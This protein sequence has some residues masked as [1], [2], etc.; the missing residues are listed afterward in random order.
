MI[1][2]IM[3]RHVLELL[4]VLPRGPEACQAFFGPAALIRRCS[5]E[6]YP[7][8]KKQGSPFA[9]MVTVGRTAN[10]DICIKDIIISRFH[11]FISQR[12]GQWVICDAGSE[13]GTFLN[14]TAL[15]ARKEHSIASG[16]CIRFGEV[17][18]FFYELTK[19]Y[20]L[21]TD[22]DG[23]EA[24]TPGVHKHRISTNLM[25]PWLVASDTEYARPPDVLLL[26]LVQL[27]APILIAL[28]KQISPDLINRNRGT[29]T[30]DSVDLDDDN[31]T[32][33]NIHASIFLVRPDPGG[34]GSDGSA[35]S[36]PVTIG[37]SPRCD[38]CIGD[39]S[40]SKTQSTISFESAAR[41][42]YLV[43]EYSR[44]GTKLNQVPLIP[45]KPAPIM[46]GDTVLFGEFRCVFL[47]PA[48]LREA[49]T[50]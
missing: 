32:H 37:S 3:R 44:N 45:G 50:R 17:E 35:Q 48:T 12:R 22:A 21:L 26:A 16:D 2:V 10:N 11:A 15:E 30:A 19:M 36:L 47:E 8:R 6:L 43:D 9:D 27:G 23:M 18:C 24:E 41:Q 46:H 34:T 40:V 1:V 49:A 13:G 33:K 29:Y 39:H 20:K 25:Q 5:G 38:I 42:Y 31:I 14:G 28:E 7:A 4:K